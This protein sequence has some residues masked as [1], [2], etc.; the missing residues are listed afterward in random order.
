MKDYKYKEHEYAKKI[1][2]NGFQGGHLSKELKLVA[3]YMKTELNYK[4]AIRKQKLYEFGEKYIEGYSRD[5]HYKLINNA[6]S[7]ASKKDSILVTIP[8]ISIFKHEIDYINNIEILENSSCKPYQYSKDCKKVML[9]LLVQMKL[10]KETYYQKTSEV[11][12]SFSFGGSN[13]KYNHIK[14]ISKINNKL[15]IHKDIIFYLVRNKLVTVL[16]N[17]IIRLDFLEELKQYSSEV[18]FTI[19]NYSHIGWYFDWYNGA[20]NMKICKSPKCNSPF[21]VVKNKQYCCEDCIPV[22]IPVSRLTKTIQCI[23]CGKNIELSSKNNRS[24]RCTDCAH[25]RRKEQVA[26]NMRKIRKNH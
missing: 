15:N 23:D 17:G 18:A 24:F 9:S 5:I 1:Y 6:L 7:Y 8:S 25:I 21:R 20:S 13:K 19:T 26:E 22:Y 3:I 11:S 16:Y 12:Q 10:N 4:P 14:K 2:E